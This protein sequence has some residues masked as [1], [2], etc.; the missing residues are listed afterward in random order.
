MGSK[1]KAADTRLRI[2]VTVDD[3]GYVWEPYEV[4]A[5]IEMELY[6]QSG[7]MGHAIDTRELLVNVGGWT[8]FQ[9]AAAVFLVRRSRG[10]A[11]SYPELA[12]AM[13][14]DSDSSVDF[15]QGDDAEDDSPKD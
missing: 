10:D 14:W 7:R 6:D 11:V 15:A 9:T 1:K 2:E 4:P 5:H 12:N 8:P 3:I 13:R